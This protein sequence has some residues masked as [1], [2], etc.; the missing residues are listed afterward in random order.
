[1]ASFA[2][3]RPA[4]LALVTA[5]LTVLPAA[6][7]GAQPAGNPMAQAPW[8]VD[9]TWGAAA[10]ARDAR[11]RGDDANASKLGVIAAQPYAR[12]FV[13]ASTP[14]DLRRELDAARSQG[15]MAVFA[16]H[17][18]PNSVCVGDDTPGHR[19]AVAY[20]D[21]VDSFA[22]TIG[23]DPAVVIVEPDELAASGCLRPA[24]RAERLSL[25]RYATRAFAALP[26]TGVYIDAGAGDWLGVKTAAKLLRSAGVAYARGFALNA[27][28]FD[29]TSAEIAYGRQLSKLTGGKHFIVN[30]AMNGRGPQ[31]T[32]RNYHVWCNPRGRSLGPL[33][34][35]RTG[36][37]LVDAFFWLIEPGLSSGSCN[38]GPRV[39]SFWTDWGLELVRNTR[40]APDFPV[41]RRG[42]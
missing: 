2:P 11:D 37:R 21:W 39:G 13:A 25:I 38:G 8:W 30:T 5:L 3:V 1:V 33:P 18:I 17:G 19:D 14:D 27:T 32:G 6:A 20:R 12:W 40:G 22:R 29:W 7:S 26:R 9:P 28:H 35:L 31:I 15:R 10:A 36:D 41:Y 23:G 4:L 24:D 16:V 34:T 42:R